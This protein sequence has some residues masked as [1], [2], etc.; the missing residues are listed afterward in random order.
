MPA[1]WRPG[2]GGGVQTVCGVWRRGG[3]WNDRARGPA[4]ALRAL[5][6]GAPSRRAAGGALYGTLKAGTPATCTRRARARGR[7][8]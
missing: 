3:G 4:R 2:E 1:S 7:N 5:A 6:C 8:L